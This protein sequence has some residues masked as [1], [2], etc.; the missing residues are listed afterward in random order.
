[1]AELI[2]YKKRT[3]IEGDIIE[4][5]AWKISKSK[6]SYSLEAEIKGE[7]INPKKHELKIDVKAITLYEFYVKKVKNK[8]EANIILDI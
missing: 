1:M 4:R 3:T 5:R 8:W 2:Y 7:K 6:D